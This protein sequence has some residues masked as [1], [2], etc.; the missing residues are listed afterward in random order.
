V[1]GSTIEA[2]F[3]GSAAT[4]A[5]DDG[6]EHTAERIWRDG[7][8]VAGRLHELG[9]GHGDRVAVRMPNGP[10][11][12]RLLAACGAGG[13]VLVSV[14]TRY[15]DAEAA[16][17]VQRSGAALTLTA[18]PDGWPA[19]EPIDPVGTADDPYVVFTT[20]GTTSRPKMVLHRQRSIADHATDVAGAFALTPESVV[21]VVMPLCG[22]F[23]LASLTGAIGGDCRTLVT[24]YELAATAAII[25]RERVTV[26]NGSDDMFHRLLLHGADLTSVRWGGYARFNAS[27]DGIVARAAAAGATLTGLYGMSEVQALFAVRDRDG[28]TAA[29]SRAGGSLASP[30]AAYRVID[31][32]LQVQGPSLFAG[33]L[34]EGGDRLDQELTDRHHD[35]DW[36]RTGDLAEPQ[37]ARTFEYLA[38]MGDALRLGGFL[39]APAEIEAAL[40]DVD[41]VEAAEVVAVDRPGGARPVAFVIAPA[42]F[43]EAAAIARCRERLARYKVPV[44]ILSI[45]AFPTTAS[46]N[47]TK[48]QKVK[49]RELADAALPSP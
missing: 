32:E 11:Y 46:A 47:G 22:T 33:Y 48:I 13:F 5:F 43:D 38:R 44:R 15:S 4:L 20:S 6:G 39:V 9:A 37:G 8:R 36:F 27:L 40:M 29:R 12:V 31:G 14:N 28:D 42:G 3:T 35:G 34:A 19:A 23:G 16:D 24:D 21:L 41:G 45:D 49:L 10:D 7:L 2:L 18:L 17:L 30:R 1:G 26:V 25:A